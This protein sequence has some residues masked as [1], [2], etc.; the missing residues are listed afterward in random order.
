MT[1]RL[2]LNGELYDSRLEGWMKKVE[3]LFTHVVDG[4]HVV[5][6]SRATDA[7]E[8]GTSIQLMKP[9]RGGT[10]R[11]EEHY[12]PCPYAVYSTL[13]IIEARKRGYHVADYATRTEFH[14]LSVPASRPVSQ[15]AAA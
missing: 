2:T 3:D 12:V 15:E 10:G 8:L 9:G 7:H 1:Y 14:P 11:V 4:H 6:A 13:C 5:L